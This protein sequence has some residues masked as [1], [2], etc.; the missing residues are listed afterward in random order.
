MKIQ[1]AEDLA[2]SELNIIFDNCSGQN[3]NNMVLKLAVWLKAAGYFKTI[4]FIFL[5]VGH[6]KNAA[7]HLFNS[8]KHKYRLQN[9]FTME[10]L[11]EKLNASESV[12]VV[13]TVPN[14]VIDYD[15]LLNDIY[16]NLP[17]R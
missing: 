2:G 10:V 11:V 4:T 17:G 3:K 13:L 5:V 8:L 7:D 16:R 6:A 14:D 9:V 1:L 15:A 12:T